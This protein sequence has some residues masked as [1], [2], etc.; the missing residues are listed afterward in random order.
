M[1]GNNGKMNRT[2]RGLIEDSGHMVKANEMGGEQWEDERRVGYL[3]GMC[4]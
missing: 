3:Q 2:M 1:D 4:S